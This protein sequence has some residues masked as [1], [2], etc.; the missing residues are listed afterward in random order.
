MNLD[1]LA[2]GEFLQNFAGVAM[3]GRHERP[4]GTTAFR[5]V[6][7]SAWSVTAFAR[8]DFYLN[9]GTIFFNKSQLI[10]RIEAENG[11]CRITARAGNE[12]RTTHLVPMQ[13]RNAI[14]EFSKQVRPRMRFA[15]PLAVGSFGV[16]S[17]VG[18]QIDDFGGD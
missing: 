8:P 18:A 17:E 12:I 15:V 7:G 3:S 9:D 14:N 2:E 6:R 5:M 13:F 10:E 11:S 4:H 1:R 16:Q